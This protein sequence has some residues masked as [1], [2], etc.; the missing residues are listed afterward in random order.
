MALL[1][2]Y[3][4]LQGGNR[5]NFLSDAEIK[6]VD[7]VVLRDRWSYLESKKGQY[8]FSV[9]ISQMKRC[10]KLKRPFTISVMTGDDC[11]PSYLNKKQPWSGSNLLEYRKLHRNIRHSMHDVFIDLGFIA[12]VWITGPTVPSQEMHLKGAQKFSGFSNSKMLAA[13][14]V[15]TQIIDEV[16][17][18]LN[19]SFTLS[20]SGENAVYR[21][22]LQDVIDYVIETFGD[23]AAFQHNS[24][25]TQTN[26]NAQHHKKLLELYKK[27]HRVGC[28]MVA[29]DN[30]QAISKFPEASFVVLYPSDL[31]K[32]KKLPKRP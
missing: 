18:D 11:N 1:R 4:V 5:N 10:V 15:A 13:W 21:T 8:D 6:S 19:T 26:V 30:V 27:G 7:F 24:L 29:P 32:I 12:E 9:L 28:E 16:W 17:G 20:I 31:T 22:Y 2:G 3:G 14:K 23:R 25:G